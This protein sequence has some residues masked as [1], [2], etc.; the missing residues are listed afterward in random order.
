MLAFLDIEPA[1]PGHTLVIPKAHFD[2]ITTTPDELLAHV[3]RVAKKIGQA[4]QK[5]LGVQGFNVDINNGAVAGQVIFHVHVHVIPRVV[6]D[7]YQM[8]HGRPYVQGEAAVIGAQLRKAL[9]L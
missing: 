4:A 6:S 1:N 9:V 3:M 5:G 2:D 8:W 7:G